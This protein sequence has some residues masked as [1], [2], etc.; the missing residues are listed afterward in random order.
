[1]NKD[2]S[3][4][5][6]L[7]NHNEKFF[8]GKDFL[9]ISGKYGVLN[10]ERFTCLGIT[11]SKLFSLGFYLKFF[12]KKRWLKNNNKLH[13][14][15]YANKKLFKTIFSLRYGIL[16]KLKI[17]GIGFRL[18]TKKDF[19][20]LKSNLSHLIFIQIPENVSVRILKNRVIFLH[21]YEIEKLRDLENSIY[22]CFIPDPFKGKGVHKDFSIV[23]LKKYKKN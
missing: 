23:Y 9:K 12:Y 13:A 16:K 14:L 2:N 15:S 3:F 5:I 22:G 21:G 20:V 11:G 4:L 10:F 18:Y 8:I 19:L 17:N 1:M 7:N 6:R